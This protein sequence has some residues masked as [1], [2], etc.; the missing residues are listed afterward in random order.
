MKWGAT[1][2]IPQL[3]KLSSLQNKTNSGISTRR[4]IIFATQNFIHCLQHKNKEMSTLIIQNL[5]HCLHCKNKDKPTN[6]MTTHNTNVSPN[7][8][9]STNFRYKKPR[10]HFAAIYSRQHHHHHCLFRP[11]YAMICCFLY[12]HFYFL[13]K[14][15]NDKTCM[16]EKITQKGIGYTTLS[17][18]KRSEKHT[19]MTISHRWTSAAGLQKNGGGSL[20]RRSSKLKRTRWGTHWEQM[21]YLSE[22]TNR[23]HKT[24][25]IHVHI[26]TKQGYSFLSPP[27]N[28]KNR[29]NTHFSLCLGPYK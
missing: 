11:Q 20:A 27:S 15:I 7:C 24:C 17:K 5:I 28:M 9:H 14:H 26:L 16:S 8:L 22:N 2:I 13:K 29:S 23:V 10:W 21:R 19:K 3:Y 4:T 1:L 25:W 12:I 6:R 18:L